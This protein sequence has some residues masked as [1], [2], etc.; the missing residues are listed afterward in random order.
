MGCYQST[1]KGLHCT[2]NILNVYP[3]TVTRTGYFLSIFRSPVQANV[4]K[5]QFWASEV[6]IAL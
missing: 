5:C 3:I 2:K 1:D 4:G 6:Y